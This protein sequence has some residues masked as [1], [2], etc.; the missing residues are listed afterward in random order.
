[1]SDTQKNTVKLPLLLTIGGLAG[2]AIGLWAAGVFEPAERQASAQCTVAPAMAEAAR[3]FATGDV[4]AFAVA[5]EAVSLP[6]LTFRDANGEETSLEAMQG[7][8]LLVNLWATWCAPCREEMPSL[9]ELHVALGSDAFGVLPISVDLG[10][11]DKPKAFY[12]EIGLSDLPFYHDGS[13]GV[14]NELKRKGHAFGLP[15]TLLVAPDGCIAG[16]MNGP[17]HWSGEDAKA[18]IRAALSG[19]AMSG[20]ALSGSG[21]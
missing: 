9:E 10:E 1:M 21:S 17:A 4:A 16:A 2:A 14:F 12:E 8:T 11:A 19:A 20:A 5:D 6:P 7:R 13:M 15:A 3:D 18:L